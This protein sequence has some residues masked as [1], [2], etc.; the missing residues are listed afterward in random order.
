[1]SPRLRGLVVAGY[2]ALSMAF[3]FLVQLPAMALTGSGDF[4]I[5][6]ARRAWSPSALWLAG[7]RVEVT[8]RERIPAGP[9]I[10]AS[11]HESA[12][13]VWALLCSIPRNLRFVAKSEL[14]RIPVFGW[15]LRLARFVRVDRRDRAQAVSALRGAVETVRSGTSLIVFPEGTRSPDARIQPFKKGPFV[16]AMDAGV[17]VVPV[18]IA[19]AAALN[20]KKR[21]E[22]RTGTIRVAIGRALIPSEFGNKEALLRAVRGRIIGLHREMGGEGGDVGLDVAERG[23]EGAT[24]M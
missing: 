4:S 18:A 5:W 13:D 3:F 16:L 22:V 15:Y 14:F 23:V 21:L 11:N 7:V 24:R 10:Y 9:A 6:L 19:G 17:P 20:P 8:G 1:M 2:C 12:L